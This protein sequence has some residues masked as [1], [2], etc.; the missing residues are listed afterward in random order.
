[1]QTQKLFWFRKVIGG[2]ILELIRP[3]FFS[4]I[5]WTMDLLALMRLILGTWHWLDA[6]PAS[7]SQSTWSITEVNQTPLSINRNLQ[8]MTLI[9]YAN[10]NHCNLVVNKWWYMYLQLLQNAKVST[11]G[12]QQLSSEPMKYVNWTENCFRTMQFKSTIKY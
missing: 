11:T 4:R 5:R 10:C 1:M 8:L 3:N 7:L 9:F 12:L 6:S 2:L